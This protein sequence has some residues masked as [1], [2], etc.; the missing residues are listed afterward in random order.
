MKMR[1]C[2]FV[3]CCLVLLLP[4]VGWNAMD[5]ELIQPLPHGAMNW[6]KGLLIVNDIVELSSSQE[7]VSVS[8][9]DVRSQIIHNMFLDLGHIRVDARRSLADLIDANPEIKDKL[10]KITQ[11]APIQQG[12]SLPD[13]RVEMVIQLSLFGG[14]SQLML[15]GEIK[16]VESIKAVGNSKDKP[17]GTVG[18]Q[19]TATDQTDD[20]YTGLIID[21]RGLR[22]QPSLVPTVVDENNVEVYGAAFVSRE[23]A[24]Q[25]GLCGYVR[26]LDEADQRR[27]GQRPLSVKGLRTAQEGYCN[28]VI[29]NSDADTLRS[30]SAHLEFLKQCRVV[31]L[32]D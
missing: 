22:V 11:N 20:V 9:A 16:Q 17:F 21:A 30:A 28:I 23:F 2:L 5:C 15:P 31:I 8:N 4:G 32:L 7:A 26:S 3:I 13:G 18:L 25:Q 19:K 10:Y 12:D 29:S 27:V 14:F 1:Q 24:V 6:T